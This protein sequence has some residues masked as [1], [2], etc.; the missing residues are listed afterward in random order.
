MWVI[1]LPFLIVPIEYVE[2][3]NPSMTIA[4]TYPELETLLPP[5]LKPEQS[6]AISR[7]IKSRDTFLASTPLHCCAKSININ[8]SGA[9]FALCQQLPEGIKYSMYAHWDNIDFSPKDPTLIWEIT[10]PVTFTEDRWESHATHITRPSI[11]RD[12]VSFFLH[13]QSLEIL[14][15]A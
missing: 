6:S 9:V 15:K 14:K 11:D 2:E 7:L 3:R 8:C 12:R 13:G 10:I 1:F 4:T 5:I